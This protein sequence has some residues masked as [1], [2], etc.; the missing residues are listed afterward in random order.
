VRRQSPCNGYENL[1]RRS[2]LERA[3]DE[4]VDIVWPEHHDNEATAL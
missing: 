3:R 1:N 4:T 2:G